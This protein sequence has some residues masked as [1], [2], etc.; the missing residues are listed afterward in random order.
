[1]GTPL[2]N[3]VRGW[4]MTIASGI[5]M[6]Q[7]TLPRGRH[8]IANDSPQHAL[9]AQVSSALTSFCAAYPDGRTS[10]YRIAVSFWHAR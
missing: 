1:M 5:G 10:A 3:D 7:L 8:G 6:Q 9:S 4:I 2:D